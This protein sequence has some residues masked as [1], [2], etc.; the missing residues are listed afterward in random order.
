[1]CLIVHLFNLEGGCTS[2]IFNSLITIGSLCCEDCPH[3]LL[4]GGEAG[5]ARLT[6]ITSFPQEVEDPG[7]N[8]ASKKGDIH[9]N[10]ITLDQ[11]VHTKF[12]KNAGSCLANTPPRH[13]H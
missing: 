11:E 9:V 3:L 4:V 1:M 2:P 6:D 13:Q 7:Q 8:L 5:Q 10:L 12:I